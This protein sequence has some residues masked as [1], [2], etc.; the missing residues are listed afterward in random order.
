MA[1][2]YC[3]S[4]KISPFQE[5]SPPCYKFQQ[6][7]LSS[8]KIGQSC[9]CIEKNKTGQFGLIGAGYQLRPL[10]TSSNLCKEFNKRVFEFKLKLNFIVT[11][12]NSYNKMVIKENMG[13]W[14]PH[15]YYAIQGCSKCN[16]RSH[17]IY[18]K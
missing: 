16:Y 14:I 12:I 17:N 13:N 10:R 2:C 5:L 9:H 6:G 3:K 8:K 18:S 7:Y 15:N 11:T 1:R 4:S